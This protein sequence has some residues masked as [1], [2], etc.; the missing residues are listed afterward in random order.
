MGLEPA[1]T[2]GAYL[3]GVPL[4]AGLKDPQHTALWVSG[5]GADESLVNEQDFVLSSDLRTPVVDVSARLVFVGYGVVAP[6]YKYD[7]LA[8]A[9]LK[10]KILARAG[11]EGGL[12]LLEQKAKANALRPFDIHATLRGRLT[13]R[14]RS[15]TSGNVAGILRGSDPKL[16]DEY[17]VYSAHLDHL[18]IGAPIDGD[19]LYNG[20]LDNASGIASVLEVARAFVALPQRPAR[21]ILFLA[22][23]GEE[24][25]LPGSEYFARN[26]TVPASSLVADINI[27]MIVAQHPLMDVV[28]LGAEHSTLSELVLE[29]ASALHLA[30]SPDPQPKQMSFIR[31]DQYSFVKQGVPSIFI[32]PGELDTAGAR[33]ANLALRKQWVATRYHSPKDKWDPAY[34]YEAMAQVARIDFLTGLSVANRPERPHWNQGDFFARYPEAEKAP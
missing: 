16:R 32:R 25:G 30:V 34:D 1:G 6:E 11:I 8:G 9:D 20:A 28:G 4:R 21:S 7:D 12:P 3:Q 15:L 10:G 22:V 13:T 2:G 19:S 31:S 17:V 24:R 23:T 18:G 33:E 27:D 26:P 5:G 29:A 14:F